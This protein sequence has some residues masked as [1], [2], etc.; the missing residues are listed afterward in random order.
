MT[1]EQDHH[2][3]GRAGHVVVD[4]DRLELVGTRA[5]RRAVVHGCVDAVD[6]SPE[7]DDVAVG[8]LVILAVDGVAGPAAR[9][10]RHLE[11]AFPVP[12]VE[13]RACG[14]AGAGNAGTDSCGGAYAGDRT[15]IPLGQRVVGVVHALVPQV[16]ELDDAASR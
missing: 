13:V 9:G 2:P 11:L 16:L 1:A 10:V 12:A 7:H 5:A 3:R 14:R 6:R 4:G 15:R 8:Q